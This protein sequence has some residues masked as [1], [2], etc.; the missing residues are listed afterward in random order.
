MQVAIKT[1]LCHSFREYLKKHLLRTEMCKYI[2]EPNNTIFSLQFS[3]QNHRHKRDFLQVFLCINNEDQ[4]ATFVS[5]LLN[6]QWKEMILDRIT[7][8]GGKK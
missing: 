7:R 6:T 8:N 4:D 5:C 2:W 1:F 3:T